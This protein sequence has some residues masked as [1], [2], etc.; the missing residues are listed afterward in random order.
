MSSFHRRVFVGDVHGCLG[1]LEDLERE[2]GL[3]DD[4]EVIL[5][6]DLVNKGP[7][8][9]G[10]LAWARERNARTLLGNHEAR[11]LEVVHT[12]PEARD[13]RAR[14]LLTRWPSQDQA[15]KDAAWIATWPLWLEWPDLAAVHAGIEPGK[16][17]FLEMSRRCLLTIR[18]WDGVGRNL[19]RDFDPPWFE[20]A[21]WPVPVVFGHWALRG[22]VDLPQAKGLDTGCVYGGRLTAWSPDENRWWQVPAHR[23]WKSL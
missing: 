23:V 13:E 22:R 9:P 20:V 17:R 1:E 15:Q 4:D 19:D 8:S 7:D 11:F 5:V 12:P 18:T 2:I 14:R 6:G 3:S 10:V 21:R 16:S